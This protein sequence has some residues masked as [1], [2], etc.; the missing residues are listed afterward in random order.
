MPWSRRTVLKGGA[1]AVVASGALTPASASASG[2]G[3]GAMPDGAHA[4]WFAAPSDTWIESLPVGNGRIGAM[5]RGG[6]Q[7]DVIA[8]NEDT[9]WSGAPP[10]RGNPTALASLPAMRAAVFAQDYHAAD[11]IA[12]AMQGPYSESYLPLAD[13][14][15]DMA[16]GAAV[17]DYRRTLDLDTA[18]AGVSYAIEGTRYTREVFAS[19]PD[20]VIVIRLSA[21]RARKISCSVGVRTPLQGKATAAGRRIVLA[22]KAPAVCQPN[23]RDV[24]NPVVYDDAPGKA[25]AFAAVIDVEVV[26]GA[27]VARGDR[28]EITNA[29]AVV[30]R[31][32]IGTGFR[33]HDRAPD[34]PVA[35]V[36]GNATRQLD[37]AGARPFATLRAAH[38]A[39]HQRFYR[40][41]SLSIGNARNGVPTDRRRV[42]N[43]TAPE[44]AMAALLFNF[45]RYLLI[46]SSRPGTQPANL[47]G[48][49][50][51]TVRAPWS[52]N[53]TSNI[54]VQMN[55]WHA[56]TA[57]LADCH[58]PLF[59]F[60][61]RVAKTG[62]VTA[63]DYYGMPGWCLHHNTDIWAMANPVGLG[64]GDP[65]WAN[66]PMAGPWLAQ[67]LWH[68]YTFGG[69]TAFLR[70]HAYPLMRGA[71]EFCAA[72]LVRNPR[73]GRLTTAPSMS[74]ENQFLAADGK[75]AGISAGCTM[76]LA[77][78]RE[79][80]ANC[81]AA[82]AVLGTDQDFT[83]RLTGLVAELEPYRV[84][85][86]G[87]LQE[88]SEDFAEQ[89]PGHRHISHLYPLYP[90]AE[91]T[92]RRTPDWAKAVRAAMQ[93]REDHGGAATGW[94][95][96][97]A[98][99]I[100][101]RLG[102]GAH[103]GYSVDQFL[104]KST[105]GNMF[106]THPGKP[107]PVFQIDGNFGIA[108]AIADM[109]VQSHDGAVAL[110]PALP[111]AWRDGEVKGLRAQ[112]GATV[113]IRWSG[114][115]VVSARIAST[116]AGPQAVRAPPGQRVVGVR[117]AGRALAFEQEADLATFRAEPGRTYTLRFANV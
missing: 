11:T 1:A 83:R 108:A 97:W 100:W 75:P 96:A 93:R 50:N 42:D 24:P 63:R 35:E 12:H 19:H 85:R 25:M 54:N 112:G 23:Y 36:I 55:Y 52:S 7:H 103:A 98:T 107:L 64:E 29:S 80:F 22:G 74:P 78:T 3:G 99:C 13:V 77:L 86:Y 20:Q 27:M 56:E 88:W 60:I 91:F 33:G 8:L 2:A 110:C 71:A 115:R 10:S 79:L 17:S 30:L 87:Q 111:A 102:D 14:L 4:L 62:A 58:Q 116:I 44:P 32:A 101:A 45:G 84:G 47:Q 26:D 18:V 61:A 95:R 46:A 41:A 15:L 40:R 53:F 21:D 92:P 38:V 104:A 109:L 114:G 94:S 113:G 28:I 37:A 90:G 6:A 67:H 66:W 34:R 81:A 49:W 59:D 65:Q 5:V 73:T 39:D 31:I 82:A 106:D 57:N 48:I 43:A 51:A 117:A 89:D 16:H 105:V 9:L 76:D 70:D 72:W 68:H 69:D